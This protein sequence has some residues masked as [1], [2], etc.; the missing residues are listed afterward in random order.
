MAEELLSICIP[1]CNRAA[2]LRKMLVTLAGQIQAASL[3][4]VVIY[5]SDNSST[6]STPQVVEEFQKLPGLQVVYSRNASNIGLS[7]NLLK[8]MSL[9]R[10]RFIWTLGDD[11][12]VAP[13]ALPK[14]VKLLR[15]HDPGFVVMFDTRYPWPIPA[16]GVYADYRA[17]ALACIQRDNV[18]ALAEHTLLSS[19]LYRAEYFDPEFG[20]K[21]IETWFPHMFGFLRPLLKHKMP[22]IIPDFAAIS[23]R[24]EERGTPTDG[25]WADIDNCWA[26]YLTWLRDEMQMPELNPADALKVARRAMLANMRQD[27]VAYFKRYWRALFQPSAY[28]FVFTRLFGVK[29]TASPYHD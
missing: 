26:T 16:P 4:E 5:I 15:Q 19:N 17:F 13:E 14:L 7:R 12:L 25:K 21:N 24:E 10:G 27:P 18:H 2:L 9:G 23:T 8:V 11:E 29:K 3:A 28:R 1:T 20:E 6:D 22:V